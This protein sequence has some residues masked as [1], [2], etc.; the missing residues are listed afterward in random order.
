[1]LYY[2]AGQTRTNIGPLKYSMK[3]LIISHPASVFVI[4]VVAVFLLTKVD[5]I[6]QFT[7]ISLVRL[8]L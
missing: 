4:N 8:R 3:A 1:M 6:I 5:K 7:V 2:T